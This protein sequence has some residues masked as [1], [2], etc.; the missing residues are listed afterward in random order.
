MVPCG[1]GLSSVVAGNTVAHGACGCGDCHRRL[2]TGGAA[3]GMPSHSSSPLA[4]MPQTGP[5]AVCTVVPCAHAGRCAGAAR[6]DVVAWTA[7]AV[8]AA[9]IT[10][11][12]TAPRHRGR[13]GMNWI[14]LIV[15]YLTSVVP[16]SEA[17]RARGFGSRSCL[18][19]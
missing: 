8:P 14:D 13:R 2:P 18:A 16:L 17:S 3:Y 10:A 9:R 19:I 15:V 1:H 6:A 12:P 11:A 7:A 4:V 5:V